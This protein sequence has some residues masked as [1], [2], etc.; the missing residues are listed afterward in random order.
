MYMYMCIFIIVV[1]T[2]VWQAG[3]TTVRF[4]PLS[5]SLTPSQ[6]LSHMLSL[7]L[8]LFIQTPLSPSLAPSQSLAL[9]PQCTPPPTK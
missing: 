1:C 4:F 2:F 5:P 7:S 9:F 6:S 3:H 8:S